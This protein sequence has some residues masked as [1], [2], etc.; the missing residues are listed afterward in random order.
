MRFTHP[1]ITLH[2]DTV[3]STTSRTNVR[4]DRDTPLMW[5]RDGGSFSFDLPDGER[6][7][8]LREG[9]DIARSETKVIC[10]VGQK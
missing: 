5:A 2:A 8:F 3:A 4:D 1:A 9:L 6:D 10:P 7:K